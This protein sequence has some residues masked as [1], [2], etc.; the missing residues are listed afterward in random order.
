MVPQAFQLPF[1]R[2]EQQARNAFSFYFDR[3]DMDFDFLPGQYNRVTLSIKAADGRGAS[4]F[5]T[6]ASSPL[7]KDHLVITTKAESSDFKKKF[8]SLAPGEKVQFFGPHG[9]FVLR[10]DENFPHVF[11]AGGIGITPFRSMIAY[12]HRKHLTIPITLF[13]SFSTPGDMVYYDELMKI[14]S[15]NKNIHVIY[16][17]TK[18]RGMQKDA[19][20]ESISA[21]LLKKYIPD[22]AE[23]TYYIVGPPGMVDSTIELL[24]KMGISDEKVKVE[25]FTG[26]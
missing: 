1:L 9:G 23:P 18:P 14:A 15:E 2:K 16:S 3:R 20:K 22:I 26:Y 25:Q 6:I 11:L 21:D 8:F 4:R 12:A 17:T 5:F 10:D 13:A 7:E 19:E 24:E